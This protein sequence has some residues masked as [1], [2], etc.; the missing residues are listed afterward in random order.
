MLKSCVAASVNKD[1]SLKKKS[2]GFYIGFTKR[3][4]RVQTDVAYIMCKKL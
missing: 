4:Q 1:A 3:I 2:L